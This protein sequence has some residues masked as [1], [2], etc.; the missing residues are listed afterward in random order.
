MS[1]LEDHQRDLEAELEQP[2]AGHRGVPVDAR[3]VGCRK[4]RAKRAP[5]DRVEEGLSFKHVCHNCQRAT[6]WNVLRRLDGGD[7]A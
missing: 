5:E 1:S 4:V 7:R 6:Y 3:C 2:Q